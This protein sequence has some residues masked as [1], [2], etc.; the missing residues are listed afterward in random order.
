M[1]LHVQ[2]LELCWSLKCTAIVH[3]CAC[4]PGT[5]LA[6]LYSVL[7]DQHVMYVMYRM[8]VHI[9]NYNYTC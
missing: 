5:V 9:H 6:D 3:V 4:V 1:L 2:L 7:L 8:Y